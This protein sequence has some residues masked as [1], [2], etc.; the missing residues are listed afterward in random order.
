[1]KLEPCL[2]VY[3]V[4]ESWYVHQGSVGGGYV[5]AN[6]DRADVQRLPPEF[7]ELRSSFLLDP[8]SEYSSPDTDNIAPCS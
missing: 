1:V 8:L 6:L 3:C 4:G 2:K 7:E 5:I